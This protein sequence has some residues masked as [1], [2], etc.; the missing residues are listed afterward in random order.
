MKTGAG[1]LPAGEQALDGCFPAG[2][3][4]NPSAQ[5]VGR[6][7][8]RDLVPRHV[9]AEVRA[10][11][12]QVRKAF[13]DAVPVEMPQIQEDARVAAAL[14]LLVDG[15]RHDIA[16]GQ[17]RQGMIA[18]HEPVVVSGHQV[19]PLPADG[20]RYQERFRLRMI[21]TGG[22]ELDELE[23][24]QVGAGPV[25]HRHAVARRDI[26]IGGIGVDLPAAPG[27]D[28]DP[29]RQAGA[30]RERFPL[31]DPGPDHAAGVVAGQADFPAQDQVHPQ[32]ILIDP[33]IGFGAAGFEQARLQFAAGQVGGVQD[34]VMGMAAFP[35]EGERAVPVLGLAA[36]IHPV[37]EQAI[38]QPRAALDHPA[39][40]GLPA[41]PGSGDEGVVHMGVEIVGGRQDGRDPALGVVG[42]RIAGFLLRHDMHVPVAR[43]QQGELQARDP[44]SDH[45]ETAVRG[46]YVSHHRPFS[47]ARPRDRPGR[48]RAPSPP[49][50]RS[51]P[52]RDRAARSA[53]A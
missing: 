35:P 32:M 30:A 8:D 17:F 4:R 21:E 1:N 36:E 22:M 38:D 37:G 2:V 27:R 34:P 5:V 11:L 48:S 10:G 12:R 20:L 24:G 42:V 26:R 41:E 45:E 49:A 28:H 50:G 47:C 31:Q 7:D 23:V 25:R 16:R 14:Q 39:H 44:G 13:Q 51:R 18:R 15:A 43:G 40:D 53:P 6:R 33:D 29:V 19:G 9:D 46:N 52:V 3:D